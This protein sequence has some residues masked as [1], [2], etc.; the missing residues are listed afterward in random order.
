VARFAKLLVLDL[1]E[2]LLHARGRSEPELPWP[3]QRRV[4]HFRVYLRPGVHEF[5]AEALDSF[6]A[7]GVW[8]SASTEYA[9]AMLE[10]IVE[11][12]RLRFVFTRDRCE[13]RQDPTLRESYWRKD[14]GVLDGFGFDQRQILIVDDKPRGLE[15]QTSNLVQ[16]MPFLGDPDDRELS[17][18]SAYLRELGEA[19]D[20][21]EVNK[22]GWWLSR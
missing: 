19:E 21:R 11:R 20:V 10:R 4:A 5:M 6:A 9:L 18:L 8:T 15:L 16:I 7:V 13:Q 14:L 17:K 1:D 3:P 22:R 2:T 12:R